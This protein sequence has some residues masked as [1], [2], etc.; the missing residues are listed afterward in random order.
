MQHCRPGRPGAP[1]CMTQTSA[2]RAR[3]AART[4][5]RSRAGFAGE[6]LTCADG[7][8]YD[9]ARAVFNAMFDRRPAV[10]ALRR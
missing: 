10:I 6:I 9:E 4:S 3:S 7:E 5:D 1:S 8:R 2:P